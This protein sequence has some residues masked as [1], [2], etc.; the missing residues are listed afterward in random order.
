[1]SVVLCSKAGSPSRSIFAAARSL[2]MASLEDLAS[3]RL[4]GKSAKG[5]V[6]SALELERR[7]GRR[8]RQVRGAD[9]LLGVYD[10]MRVADAEFGLQVSRD[11][12]ADL[13][14]E[15]SNFLKKPRPPTIMIAETKTTRERDKRDKTTQ[16][17]DQARENNSN[18]ANKKTNPTNGARRDPKRYQIQT[19]PEGAKFQDSA[20]LRIWP[21]FN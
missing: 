4:R 13:R 1:M 2:D 19:G 7:C 15:V 5:G 17:E 3:P 11:I 8:L 6:P 14:R 21:L 18:N 10:V 12:P 9:L 16:E 20:T